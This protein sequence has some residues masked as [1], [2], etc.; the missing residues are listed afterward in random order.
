MKAFLSVTCG[1]AICVIAVLELVLAVV[2]GRYYAK[3]KSKTVLC[4]FLITCGLFIDA[5]LIGLGNF[6]DAQSIAG[7]SRIRFISHGL[8]IPL[9]FPVCVFALNLN[10]KAERV[11][12]IITA[13]LMIA[14]LAEAFA[15][16]LGPVEIAGVS[17]M[18]SVKGATP[19]WAE[20]ISRVLS[21]GTVFP[22][23][24]VGIFCWIKKKT[25]LL[26]LSGFFMFFF[27]AIGPA[28]GNS[29]YIFYVSMYGEILMVLFIYLFARSKKSGAK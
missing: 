8:L 22:L 28:T 23:M 9:L 11:I 15:T 17:R 13:V 5:F 18:A 4:A 12:F 3:T 27:S 20:K 6:I 7:L 29:E 16:V 25:P 24:G 14:G 19:V 2:M 1:P 21:F 10:K 26:F